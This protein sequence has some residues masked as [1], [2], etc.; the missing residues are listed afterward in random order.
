[1]KKA[2]AET[3]LPPFGP[4]EP[5]EALHSSPKAAIP[6]PLVQVRALPNGRRGWR[7]GRRSDL[8]RRRLR[9]HAGSNPAPC[10]ICAPPARAGI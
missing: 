6:N 9:G 4:G 7:N 8:A 3:D 10:T 5:G 1:M 2:H